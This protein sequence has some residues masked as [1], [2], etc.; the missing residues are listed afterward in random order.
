MAE[1]KVTRLRFTKNE[2]TDEKVRRAAAKAECAADRAEKAQ[3]KLPKKTKL[4]IIREA[5]G[6]AS[7]GSKLQPKKSADTAV[8]SKLRVERVEVSAGR[9]GF[10]KQ[11]G[12]NV[13]HASAVRALNAVR[14]SVD[15]EDDGNAGAEAVRTGR[16]TA[17]AT[18]ATVSNVRYYG[19]LKSHKKQNG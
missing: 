7:P 4:R 19:K 11:T 15:A 13:A 18:G 12:K 17:N 9:P 1:R 10:V 8:R 2:L 5:A 6:G 3:S 14:D 16:T